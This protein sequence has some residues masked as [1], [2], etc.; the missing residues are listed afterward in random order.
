MTEKHP[1]ALGRLDGK[2]AVVTGAARGIG[3]ACAVAFAR[4]GADV[5]GVDIACE[6]SS[7]VEFAPATVGDLTETGAKVRQ[8]GVPGAACR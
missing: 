3:R 6:V 7:I 5:I 8:E 4:A 1:W 2:V